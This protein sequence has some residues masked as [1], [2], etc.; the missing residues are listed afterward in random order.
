[1]NRL[2]A[3]FPWTFVGQVGNSRRLAARHGEFKIRRRFPTCPARPRSAYDGFV[4]AAFR[5]V[6]PA[7]LDRLLLFM[8]RLYERDA[9]SFDPARSRRA[10]EWLL[11]NPDAGGIWTIE[12]EGQ[13]AGYIVLTVSVSLEFHGPFC[14]LD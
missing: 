14:L 4:H 5:P 11:A 3:E 13:A 10:A 7:D 2:N 1:M 6:I 9:L 8:A 12:A